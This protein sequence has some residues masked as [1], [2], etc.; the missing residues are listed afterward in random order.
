MHTMNKRAALSIAV[1]VV[2]ALLAG[3]VLY[4]PAL[5]EALVSGHQIPQH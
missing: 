5:L 3:V 1:I 2:V 4:G